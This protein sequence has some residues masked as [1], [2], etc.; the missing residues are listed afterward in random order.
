M[1]NICLKDVWCCILQTI[2]SFFF[3][4]HHWALCSIAVTAPEFRLLCLRSFMCAVCGLPLPKTVS[5][6]SASDMYDTLCIH[7]DLDLHK[8][9]EDEWVNKLMN[10]SRPPQRKIHLCPKIRYHINELVGIL[11]ISSSAIYSASYERKWD[12]T[13]GCACWC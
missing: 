7:R 11:D 8:V 6:P 2:H 4:Q 9:I 10:L 5:Y 13:Q 1:S 12:C 3:G